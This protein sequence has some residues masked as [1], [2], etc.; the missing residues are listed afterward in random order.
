M[1]GTYKATGIT[2]KSAPFGEND[3]L[4]TILTPEQGLVRAVAPGA[5]KHQSRLRGRSGIFVVNRLLLNRGRSLDKVLQADSINSFPKLSQDLGKLTA[6][7][8]LAELALAQAL[9]QQPQT[10]LFTLLQAHLERLDSCGRGATPAFLVHGIFHLLALDGIAPQVHTCCLT[11]Q[12]LIPQLSNPDWR[13]GFAAS[14][15]GA[16]RLDVAA[17]QPASSASAA[18]ESEPPPE[19]R[20]VVLE[21]PKIYS[22]L[23]AL[24]LIL[25]QQLSRA[26]LLQPDGTLLPAIAAEVLGHSQAQVEKDVWLS[27]ERTLRHYLQYHIDKTI[28]SAALIESCF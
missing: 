20:P 11:Q 5:R 22:R 10:E 1:S 12:P 4:L 28:H 6:G 8:Y 24:P 25:L 13:V 16:F 17:P 9:S 27:L 3:R 14:L 7:Q 26:A 2:L 18:P 15:G 21:Q 19:S 23:T